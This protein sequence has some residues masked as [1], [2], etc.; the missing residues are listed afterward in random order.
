[1]KMIMIDWDMRMI[2]MPASILLGLKSRTWKSPSSKLTWRVVTIELI[3]V[4]LHIKLEFVVID[5]G[6]DKLAFGCPLY[7]PLKYYWK[8]NK[9]KKITINK[10]G[11]CKKNYIKFHFRSIRSWSKKENV[12][13]IYLL[14][15]SLFVLSSF[16]DK[17]NFNEYVY[18]FKLLHLLKTT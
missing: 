17:S 12:S 5:N 14:I 9:M 11:K 13:I 8:Y 16:T 3:I 2:N 1:M 6:Q 18:V 10:I 4:K 15:L 7:I